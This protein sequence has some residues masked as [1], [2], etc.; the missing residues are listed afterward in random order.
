MPRGWKRVDGRPV[1]NDLVMGAIPHIFYPV[2]LTEFGQSAPHV[3]VRT[4]TEP[5]GM[6][7]ALYDCLDWTSDSGSDNGLIGLEMAGGWD[8]SGGGAAQC[9]ELLPLYCMQVDHA[10]GVAVPPVPMARRAF[11]AGGFSP[12]SGL[13]GADAV[14]LRDA[15]HL[16]LSGTFRAALATTAASAASRFH[17]TNARPYARLDDVVVAV[18]DADL[19]KPVPAMLAPINVD[20]Y[21]KFSF[22]TAYVGAPAIDQVATSANCSNWSSTSGFA[23]YGTANYLGTFAF[24]GITDLCTRGDVIYC[25][26]D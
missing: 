25:L 20:A 12:S 4:G 9:S 24:A 7:N 14:C 21:G 5:T 18:V 16:G 8:W 19:F 26:E 13:A 17:P 15:Q 6:H 1:V 23:V 3:W 11:T 22:G 10:V 2:R